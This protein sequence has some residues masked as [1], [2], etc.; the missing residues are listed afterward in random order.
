MSEKT[1]AGLFQDI[2]GHEAVVRFLEASLDYQTVSHAY[3]YIGPRGV[4]KTSVLT[5]FLS[6]LIGGARADLDAFLTYPD[7]TLVR[8]GTDEKTGKLKKNIT[9][10]QIREM[11][12]RLAMGSFLNSWKIAVV[13]GA[14]NLSEEAANALLKTLEEPTRKTVIFL[15][16]P[17]FS[18]VPETV[19]SRCQ[20]VRFRL[21]G[22]SVVKSG[23]ER[24]GV[25]K[26]EA[27]IWASA[28]GGRPGVAIR[29]AKDSEGRAEY[30]QTVAEGI[31][32]MTSPLHERLTVVGGIIPEKAGSIETAT[33]LEEKLTV[34]ET[35]VR[36]GLVCS[37]GLP[38]QT[39]SGRTEIK[40]WSRNRRPAEVTAI[41]RLFE[42]VRRALKENV[43]P[44]LAVERLAIAL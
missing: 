37:L 42:D 5:R 4:G 29:L 44:R 14:E 24:M 3:L 25:A 27:Q 41:L 21:V 10:E 39:M 15:L 33:L 34:W 28:A 31:T 12:G 30:E 9:V 17:A 19:A 1:G 2:I 18:G 7:F 16:A 35:L 13:D 6:G 36:D 11:R 8:R 43:N 32:L 38:E 40:T 20:V 26:G 23:L 22:E